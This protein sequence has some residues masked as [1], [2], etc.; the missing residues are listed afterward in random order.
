MRARTA[1]AGAAAENKEP[2]ADR[3][4]VLQAVAIP[5]MQR[6]TETRV[7]SRRNHSVWS[8]VPSSLSLSLSLSLPRGQMDAEERDRRRRTSRLNRDS[9]ILFIM[10]M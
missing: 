8:L 10:E 2:E 5:L 6:I 7:R 9:L 1:A 4:R 3:G